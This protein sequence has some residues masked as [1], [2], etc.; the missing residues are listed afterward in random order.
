MLEFNRVGVIAWWING[1]LLRRHSFGF[2][3]VKLLNLLT[4]LFRVLDK[5]LPLPPLSLI[6]VLSKPSLE[7]VEMPGDSSL[8]PLGSA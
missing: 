3:Q 7:V 2:L 6:A 4:P 8:A 5:F 1:K